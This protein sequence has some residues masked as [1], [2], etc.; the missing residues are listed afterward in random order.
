MSVFI[1]SRA[2]E[3]NLSDPAHTKVVSLAFD[4]VPFE[5]EHMEGRRC[6]LSWSGKLF[7]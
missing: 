3:E 6:R 4:D 7:I 1:R 5:I 2:R